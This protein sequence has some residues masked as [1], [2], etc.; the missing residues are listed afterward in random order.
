M[1]TWPEHR[2]INQLE[3]FTRPHVNRVHVDCEGKRTVERKGVLLR[4]PTFP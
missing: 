4:R 1:S 2:V 3:E